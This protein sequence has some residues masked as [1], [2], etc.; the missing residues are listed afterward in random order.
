MF[1]VTSTIE[2]LLSATGGCW[3]RACFGQES[4]VAAAHDFVFRR[5]RLRYDEFVAPL[6]KAVQELYKENQQLKE[7]VSD[8]EKLAKHSG[9]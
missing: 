1:R 2:K 9:R 7:R 4:R 6:V 8:L 3:K 5:A